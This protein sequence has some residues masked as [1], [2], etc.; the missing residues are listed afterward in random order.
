VGMAVVKD[1]VQELGGSLEL[2]TAA[3]QGTH[4]SIRLPLTLAI[5]D[6]F[7]VTAG[8]QTFAVPQAAVA[9]I[10]ALPDGP[11][12]HLESN[13][14]VLYRGMALPLIRLA[15]FFHLPEED[16]RY[17]LVFGRD[18]AAVGLT[19]S[20]VL[21]RREIVVRPV[22]DPLIQVDGVSGATELGDGRLIL[23]LDSAALARAARRQAAMA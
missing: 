17:V 8:A 5:A 14:L 15:R 22:L 7:I 18:A 2:A 3:G 6:A 23:I 12:T 1:A 9:E 21:A 16:D 19:V 11:V 4:F 13:E 20:G 10:V